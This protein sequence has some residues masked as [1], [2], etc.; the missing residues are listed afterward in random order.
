MSFEDWEM[1]IRIDEF[2][3]L[4]CLC[5]Q[6]KFTCT[7]CYEIGFLEAKRMHFER[8]Q[9]KWMKK[10]QKRKAKLELEENSNN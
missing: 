4:P 7:R 1:Q 5:D 8:Q 2:K 6:E 3:Q 10:E 9:K